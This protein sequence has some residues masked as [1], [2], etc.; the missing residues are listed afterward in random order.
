V[1]FLG[2]RK[3]KLPARRGIFLALAPFLIFWLFLSS[4]LEYLIVFQVCKTPGG[5]IL[6]PDHG[7]VGRGG[8]VYRAHQGLSKI[9]ERFLES[10]VPE[11]EIFPS[12][13]VGAGT[14]L[15]VTPFN[16]PGPVELHRVS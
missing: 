11:V 4:K 3:P 9:R 2:K 15:L 1:G 6:A 13:K 5:L 8:T 12:G 10:L 16:Q 7:A 14:N